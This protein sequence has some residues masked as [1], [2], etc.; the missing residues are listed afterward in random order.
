[1]RNKM[2]KL[3]TS[4]LNTCQNFSRAVEN[5]EDI[6]WRFTTHMLRDDRTCLDLE[7]DNIQN[8]KRLH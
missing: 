7:R 1:M 3:F 2:L 6:S 4:A 5:S 8:V